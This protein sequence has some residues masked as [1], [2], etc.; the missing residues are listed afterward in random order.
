MVTATKA[1]LTR[2]IA[3]ASDVAITTTLRARPW[4]PRSSSRKCRT[5]L[6]RSPTSANTLTCAWLAFAISPRRTLL[7]TPEP[8]NIPTLWPLP[9]VSMP[10]MARMPV[11]RGLLI[12]SLL[13]GAG[14]KLSRPRCSVP[15][16]GPLPSIGRPRPS[17]TLPRRPG[18][19]V[20]LRPWGFALTLSP[21]LIV[22]KCSSGSSITLPSRK[23][24]TSAATVLSSPQRISHSSPRPTL[25]PADSIVRPATRTTLPQHWRRSTFLRAA[26]NF[27]KFIRDGIS[28]ACLYIR[29]CQRLADFGKVVFNERFHR[30]FRR[31]YDAFGAL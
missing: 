24:M 17:S 1:A 15:A 12:F 10:S 27:S 6:P 25:G 9:Q 4:G 23:P 20:K 21:G 19:T 13:S 26:W 29:L 5:S 2:W 11:A 30:R 14:L 22:L 31:F 28:V 3:V 18:P 8:A 16:I 7:P